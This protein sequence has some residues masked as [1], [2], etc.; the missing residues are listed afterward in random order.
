[1]CIENY[2]DIDKLR[3]KIKQGDILIISNV[4]RAITKY[5]WYCN[6]MFMLSYND[7][8]YADYCSDAEYRRD[9]L[10]ALKSEHYTVSLRT[11]KCLELIYLVSNNLL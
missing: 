6:G 11:D 3:L 8:E 2:D 4:H 1:M 7:G 5:Y 9:L 10:M